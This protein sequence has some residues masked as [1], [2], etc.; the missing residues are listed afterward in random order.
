MLRIDQ[1][2][3]PPR[4]ARWMLRHP[5]VWSIGIVVVITTCVSGLHAYLETA[6]TP[7]VYLLGVLFCA[8]TVGLRPAVLCAIL[9]F[10]AYN[11]F[12]VQPVHTFSVANPQDVLRLLLFLITALIGGGL[13]S[14]VRDRAE[15]AQQR[16]TEMEALYTLSQAISVQLDFSQVAPIILTTTLQLLRSSAATMFLPDHAGVMQEVSHA[17]RWPKQATVV[18][19]PLSNGDQAIGL[20]RVVVDAE[21]LPLPRDQQRLLETLASQ[22]SL[23][24]QRSMLA[25]A[26]AQANAAVASDR[27]KSVLLSAVSHDFRTPLASITAAA[28]E[29]LSEDV[30]WSRAASHNFATVIWNQANRLNY[31]I[32]NLLDLTRIEA[33]VLQP[34]IGWY[35]IAEILAKALERI[36]A[37][38]EGRSVELD[39]PDT[40]PL[41]PVDYVYL[42]Q[43]LWNLLQ[44]AL[45]YSPPETPIMIGARLE[46]GQLLLAIAD[47][48]TGIPRAERQQVFTTFYRVQQPDQA[49]I[50]GMGIGL[51]ICKG[52]ID[53]HHGRIEILDREGGGTIV[54]LALPLERGVSATQEDL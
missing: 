53:A 4:V 41:L 10:F 2:R 37:E 48:G 3:L 42:E 11:F 22:A 18:D 1:F 50:E 33:G 28:D 13:A 45:K 12:F 6:N 54:Q 44:N 7:L 27:L 25:Q 20:L 30:T 21:R 39:V 26:A 46:R 40:L 9:S 31:L 15:L 49:N 34:N 19:A 29:L 35:N 17:G 51:A 23:A 52:L 36:D 16:A 43:V 8:T 32:T 24:F 38:L 5:L 14:R 47:R